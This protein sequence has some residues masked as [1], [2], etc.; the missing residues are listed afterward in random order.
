MWRSTISI[1]IVMLMSLS[2][3]ADTAKD[4]D[5]KD[6]KYPDVENIGNRDINGRIYLFFPNF[7]SFEKEIQIGAQYAAQIEQ[8]VRLLEDPVVNEYVND[9]VQNLVRHSDAKVPFNVRIIDSDEVNAFALPGGYIFIHKGLIQ[10][11][12]ME[13]ELV[14]VLSHEIAHVAARHASERL[15]K[16]QLLQWATIPT[17][18]VGGVGGVA[19]RNGVGLALNLQIL[20]ITRGSEREADT[21]GVQYAWHAGYDPLG[22]LSFFEKMLA[23]EKQQPGKFASWFRTH[24]P[25]PERMEIVQDIIDH[26]LPPKPKYIVSSSRFDDIKQRL[27]EYD[28]ERMAMNRSTPSGDED[29][30]RSA[31]PTLKRRTDTD[32]AEAG[33]GRPESSPP[34][35][36]KEKDNEEK[37]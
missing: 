32:P 9:M 4:D 25:T 3:A 34:T 27:M 11:A 23:K 13:D 26:C 12:D 17:I 37:K 21:L 6:C 16:A 31:K 30:S 28:N 18:F 5:R 15:T 19:L 7:I 20:G 14:G 36:K 33:E 8:S 22:F 10:M 24:P 29:G 1:A 2:L 35:L